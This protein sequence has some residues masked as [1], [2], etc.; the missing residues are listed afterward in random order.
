LNAVVAAQDFF[1]ALRCFSFQQAKTGL[2]GSSCEA[3]THDFAIL[4][5]AA[6]KLNQEAAEVLDYQAADDN[7]TQ[8]CLDHRWP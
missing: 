4:N 2:A 1:R 3:E 7:F 8:K 5:D 6:D